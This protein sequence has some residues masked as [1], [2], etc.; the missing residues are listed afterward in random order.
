MSSFW[1]RQRAKQQP[2][3]P[4]SNPNGPWWARGSDVL[5]QRQTV[6][7]A[8]LQSYPGSPEHEDPGRVEGH[9]VSKIGLLKGSAEECPV[10][11]VDPGTGIRGNMYRPT[12][13]TAMRCF[14]C[15][16]IEGNRFVGETSGL[17]AVREGP[18]HRAR[19][20]DSGGAVVHNYR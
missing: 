11:P 10:C 2:Q 4:V 18:S 3:A 7:Q 8:P 16:Q 14:D 19:Q 20:T 1:E 6:A 9:D 13:S 5:A 17:I 15:G 12:P